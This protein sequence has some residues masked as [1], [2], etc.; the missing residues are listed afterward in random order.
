MMVSFAVQ[1][2]V[3]LSHAVPMQ[4]E[5]GEYYKQHMLARLNYFRFTAAILL[6]V[7]FIIR[8]RHSSDVQYPFIYKSCEIVLLNT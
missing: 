1:N 6:T 4:F 5:L 7:V 2:L 8:K 3:F